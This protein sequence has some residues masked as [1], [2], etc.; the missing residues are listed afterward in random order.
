MEFPKRIYTAEEVHRAAEL[1]EKGYKHSLRAYGSREF[2]KRA[3][4]ALELVR[5]AG[6]YD[7]LRA[8]IRSIVKIDGIS[9]LREADAAIWVNEYVLQNLVDAASLFIEKANKMKEYLEGNFYSGGVAEGR[10]VD[11][12]VEFLK[13]LR[14]KSEKQEIREECEKLIRSWTETMFL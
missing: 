10:S 11:K 12:R 13:A 3:E 6:Y 5:A 9:Q 7:F 8:Y 2:V 1:V 14:R 4:K